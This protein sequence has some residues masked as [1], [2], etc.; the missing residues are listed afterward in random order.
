MPPTWTIMV[1]MNADD[2]LANFAVESLKQLKSA[3]SDKVTVAAQLGVDGFDPPYFRRYVFNKKTQATQIDDKPARQ[4]WDHGNTDMTDPNALKDFIDWVQKHCKA[5]YYCLIFWGHG[6][7]LL[8]Q[9]PPRKHKDAGSKTAASKS[10]RRRTLYFT[11]VQLKEAIQESGLGDK[12]KIIG[13]DACSMGTIEFTYELQG[14]ADFMIASQ[15]EVPDLSFPYDTLL[16]RF[17]KHSAEVEPLCKNVV[18]GYVDAYQDYISNSQNGM[19]PVTLS[20]LR[21]AEKTEQKGIAALADAFQSLSAEL[22]ALSRDKDGS[23][24]IVEARKQCQD[25]VG[26]L[27]VDI[28]DF[29]DKLSHRSLSPELKQICNKVSN[30]V[31]GTIDKDREA[32]SCAVSKDGIVACNMVATDATNPGSSCNGL[33]IYFPYLKDDE[34]T[35][36]ESRKLVKGVGGSQSDTVGKNAEVVNMAA[37]NLQYGIRR[38][39][40]EDIEEWYQDKNFS[41]SRASGWYKFI[42]DGWSRIL[43]ANY[44]EELDTRYS[45]LQCARNL[46]QDVIASGAEVAEPQAQDHLRRPDGKSVTGGELEVGDDRDGSPPAP[47][48]HAA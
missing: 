32:G 46:A 34:K 35:G 4:Q 18:K 38:E 41:W 27:F 7:V 13:M 44:P 5:D 10:S 16:K 6:P 40:I 2:E 39:L 1:Y 29:C 45:A 20:A 11:P 17:E 3:A 37:I 28:C 36:I 8:Y 22:R 24:H 23:N 25:F 19:K 47:A 31:K 48:R 14:V 26:G 12:L 33:S 43:V 30:A 42:R 9:A 21:L 15:E